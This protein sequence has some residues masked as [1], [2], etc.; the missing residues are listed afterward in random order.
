M[1]EAPCRANEYAG[2]ARG[3]TKGGV[4]QS[5]VNQNVEIA[6]LNEDAANGST[7]KVP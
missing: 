5:C 7:P 4:K 1:F 3:T 6:A 2:R